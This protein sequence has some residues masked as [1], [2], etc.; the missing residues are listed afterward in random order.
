MAQFERARSSHQKRIRRQ[1][2]LDAAV[3]LFDSEPWDAITVAR[4][5]RRA[6][7]AKG[8]TY[9]YFATKEAVFLEVLLGETAV[10]ATALRASVAPTGRRDVAWRFAQSLSLRPRLLRLLGLQHAVLEANVTPAAA[11]D[12]RRRLLVIHTGLAEWVERAAGHTPGAGLVF[13][14]RAHALAVGLGQMAHPAKAV[15]A[16]MDADPALAVLEVDFAAELEQ[17]LAALLA[18]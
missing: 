13:L 5:A 4:M 3:A 8:T 10:W 9:R 2:L 11:G 6:G 12:F 17:S 7:L 18:G 14:R 1:Q 16:A 15:R